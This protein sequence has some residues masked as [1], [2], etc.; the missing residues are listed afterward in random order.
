MLPI[1]LIN[2]DR[3]SDRLQTFHARNQ[4]ISHISRFPAVDGSQFTREMLQAQ[5]LMIGD[6]PY[7]NG[8][9]GCA[10]SHIR[11][12]DQCIEND[13][14]MT[15]CED[16]ALFHSKFHDH[17]T[18]FIASLDKGWD[19][20]LWG[21]N[22]DSICSFELLPG[23][24]PCV[25]LFNQQSMREG[26]STYPQ[27]NINPQ[28]FRVNRAFGIMC[29]SLSPEGARKLKALILPLA[30]LQVYFPVLNRHLPNNGIDIAMNAFYSELN[31]YISLPPLVLSENNHAISTVQEC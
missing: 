20:I 27:L 7:T 19:L 3:S 6:L 28:L 8:A 30:P 4:G 14:P 24:S 15:V 5:G 21:W 17:S 2:L 25:G 1:F 9:L 29:Y 13:C 26:I 11:F 23:I 31:A 16:D 12:W 18:K 22:F 10:M